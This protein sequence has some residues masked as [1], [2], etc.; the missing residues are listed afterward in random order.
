MSI[1]SIRQNSIKCRNNKL[2]YLQQY[3]HNAKNQPIYTTVTKINLE[4]NCNSRKPVLIL[5]IV[6]Q[7]S[8]L[9]EYKLIGIEEVA[10]EYIQVDGTSINAYSIKIKQK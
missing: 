2:Q 7:R 6:L 5:A 4:T 8:Y 10:V 3:I 1:W 9:L